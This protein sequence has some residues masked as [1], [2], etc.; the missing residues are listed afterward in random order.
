MAAEERATLR[1][2]AAGDRSLPAEV[3]RGLQARR[4]VAPN[5]QRHARRNAE[6]PREKLELAPIAHV[7]PVV[8]L[9]LD[10]EIS[11]PV[12]GLHPPGIVLD[13]HHRPRQGESADRLDGSRPGAEPQ[14]AGRPLNVI[15][16]H[17]PNLRI[18][19]LAHDEVLQLRAVAIP[20][21]IQL[22]A[23]A[24]IL[25]RQPVG[26]GLCPVRI[27]GQVVEKPKNAVDPVRGVGPGAVQRNRAP[28]DEET[29]VAPP[30]D[31]ALQPNG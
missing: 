21:V 4:V 22:R 28:G 29:D 25:T 17:E 11:R 6:R 20:V 24:R 31:V 19:V 9:E 5:R 15:S 13:V 30:H 7:E 14:L 8:I 26:A 1:R 16:A 12:P 27:D 18:K 3:V 10:A 23:I 2:Q